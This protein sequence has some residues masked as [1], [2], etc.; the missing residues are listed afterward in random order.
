MLYKPLTRLVR[1]HL[2][3]K[4]LHAEVKPL[5]ELKSHHPAREVAPQ[6]KSGCL[7]EQTSQGT[8]VLQ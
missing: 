2:I 8:N 6:Q 5:H 3:T 1:P 4:K 7:V